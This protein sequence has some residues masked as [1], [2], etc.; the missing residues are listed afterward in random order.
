MI[1]T[2][3][4]LDNETLQKDQDDAWLFNQTSTTSAAAIQQSKTIQLTS[5]VIKIQSN[6]NQYELLN[7][8]IA[9]LLEDGMQLVTPTHKLKIALQPAIQP[10]VNEEVTCDDVN[11]EQ[12]LSLLPG[13][14]TN[15]L[16]SSLFEEQEKTV[17]TF[18]IA[19]QTNLAFLETGF[20]KLFSENTELHEHHNE[21][22]KSNN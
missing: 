8:Q 1:L 16:F 22:N 7:D 20:A 10:T 17:S 3:T 14:D 18:P 9:V 2:I 19:E 13:I 5:E 4:F 21:K 6:N 15:N 12:E 11:L